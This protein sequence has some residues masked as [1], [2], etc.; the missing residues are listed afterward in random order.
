MINTEAGLYIES[1]ELAKKLKAYRATG[2][3][4]ANSYRVCLD[5]NGQVVWETMKDGE[6]VRY[7]NKPETG[8]RPK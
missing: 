7:R 8:Y 6:R 3:V 4:P 2:V 1:P 5:T